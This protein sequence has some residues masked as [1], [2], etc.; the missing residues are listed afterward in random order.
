MNLTRY[1]H[2]IILSAPESA[3]EATRTLLAQQLGIPA[4]EIVFPI[5][6][7]PTGASPATLRYS[8]GV[9]TPEQA[10]QLLTLCAPGGDARALLCL[11]HRA[12][13]ESGETTSGEEGRVNVT[14]VDVGGVPPADLT[15][16]RFT[17]AF[18]LASRGVQRVQ[19]LPF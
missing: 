7:S 5:R 17:L 15:N 8:H 2:S 14:I 19:D 9:Y 3:L 16:V 13:N 4:E 18:A 10:D 1:T 6:T 12:F 11:A